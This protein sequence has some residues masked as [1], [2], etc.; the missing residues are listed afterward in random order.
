MFDQGQFYPYQPIQFMDGLLAPPIGVGTG[1]SSLSLVGSPTSS[2]A[3][4]V[5]WPA[6]L[7]AGDLAVLLDYAS[8][9]SVPANVVPTGFTQIVTAGAVVARGSANYK[10]LTGTETGNITGMSGLILGKLLY[11]FRADSAIAAVNPSTW[12]AEATASDPAAQTVAASS[13]IAPL[14]VLAMCFGTDGNVSFSTASPAFTATT[15]YGSSNSGMGGYK[16]YLS[17][18]VDHLVDM[19]DRNSNVLLSGYVAVT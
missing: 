10:I 16:I 1:I 14:I 15:Q 5:A 11:I 18:P 17:S 9:F 2:S 4:T 13:G 6:G 3:A 8:G 12:N 19:V 7:Q